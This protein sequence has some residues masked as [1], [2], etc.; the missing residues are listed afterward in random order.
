M[1][2]NVQWLDLTW[3][4]LSEHIVSSQ[5]CFLPPIQ[6]QVLLRPGTVSHCS[7]ILWTHQGFQSAGNIPAFSIS[8]FSWS[9]SLSALVQYLVCSFSISALRFCSWLDHNTQACQSLCLIDPWPEDS[10]RFSTNFFLLTLEEIP[11]NV[12][13]FVRSSFF[14]LYW[15]LFTRDGKNQLLKSEL[16]CL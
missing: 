14:S 10:V 1:Q 6:H 8:F 13:I 4:I 12:V 5:L 16:S 15:T 3:G 11:W 2:N 7:T 9:S